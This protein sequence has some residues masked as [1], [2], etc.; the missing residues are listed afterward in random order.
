MENP[1]HV[2]PREP[3]ILGVVVVTVG[4][5]HGEPLDQEEQQNGPH[6]EL[7][8]DVPDDQRIAQ[9][10]LLHLGGQKIRRIGLHLPGRVKDFPPAMRAV[11][12]DHLPEVRIDL[13]FQTAIFATC[14]AHTLII[15]HI[16]FILA[17]LK[18]CLSSFFFHE[19]M[20]RMCIKSAFST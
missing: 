1:P 10:I 11:R 17:S 3:G 18:T 9:A 19:Y 7:K 20:G 4:S 6:G 16:G 5:A 8:P 15:Y 2:L 12:P 14:R 13:V